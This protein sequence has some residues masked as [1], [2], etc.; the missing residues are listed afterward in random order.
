MQA[1]EKNPTNGVGF[2]ATLLKE[3]PYAIAVFDR[4]M[5]YIA[6]SHR[7]L[8]EYNMGNQELTG[9]SHYDI[10]PEISTEWRNIHQKCLA[11]ES[12]S[13]SDD[14]F[15]RLDGSVDYVSWKLVPWRDCDGGICG[16]IMFTSVSTSQVVTEKQ[17]H[18]YERDLQVLLQT[19]RAVPWRM[20]VSTETFT[21]MGSQLESVVGYPE[22]SWTDLTT[23][24][25]HIHPDDRERV[26][27]IIRD[28]MT[29]SDHDFEYRVITPSN[30]GV[31]IRSVVSPI[32]DD[33]DTIVAIAGLCIDIN[34]QKLTEQKLRLSEKQYRS[35]IALSGDG[36]WLSDINGTLLEVNDAYAKLSGYSNDELVGMHISE[37]DVFDAP[38][39][40]ARQNENIIKNGS[41]LFETKH[42][43]KNGELWDV[44]ISASYIDNQGG[45]FCVFARDITERK[46]TQEELRLI[47]MVFNNTSEG[48]VITNPQGTIIDVNE[49]YCEITGYSRNEMLG[50]KPSKI[51]S[52][53]HD[54]EFY[55]QMWSSL[56][57]DGYWV[58]EIW[59]RRKNGEVFP[60]W[61]NINAV[62][63]E[64]GKLSHYVG[65]FSDISSLKNIESELEYMAYHDHLTGLPNRLLFM[66]RVEN[67]IKHCHR[68]GFQ[69]AIL[70]LDIDRFKLINDSL[71]HSAGDA[72][73]IEVSKRI[74]ANLREND[75]VARMGGDEFTIL[76]SN[77]GGSDA[78]A[79]VAKNIMKQ[80]MLPF[81]LHGEELRLGSSIGI[82]LYPDDGTNFSTLTRHADAAMYEAKDAGRG[83]YRFFSNE[84]DSSVHEH[85]SLE[86][87]L[88][89]ALENGEF[90][91]VFQPQVNVHDNRVVHCEAL[92]RWKH[93]ERG[94][95]PPDKFIPIAETTG[96][97]SEIGDWIIHESCRIISHWR[98]T[99]TTL[100]TVSINLSA[101]QFR[102]ESLVDK[103][104]AILA[105][106]N[107]DAT[108]VE[109]EITETAAMENAESTMERLSR[110]TEKG[111]SI[112]I[113]DFGTG[114]S[115]LSYLKR[116]PVNKLKLDRSFVMDIQTDPNDA[117][118]S[119]AIIQMA[120]SLGLEI[121]AEGVET[122]EQRDFLAA[123]G[124]SIMQGYLYSKPLESSDFLDY[125][126]NIR[127][128]HTSEQN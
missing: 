85:L 17:L 41:C 60:K 120:N 37:L 50:E 43:K 104:L 30:D 29:G 16:I 97:I 46:R 126:I 61:L 67:E 40:V 66:D 8:E 121:V 13:R 102:Q 63:D 47:A 118:I 10:F 58:G 42:R 123:K 73:L 100:P 54:K 3:V 28:A 21:S 44:E 35:V 89:R 98:D 75:T 25:S 76:L 64:E 6:Y 70:F 93:P 4:Q 94:L 127:Y 20:N 2:L 96:L 12:L 113:D 119:S 79:V 5:R 15:P 27:S 95:V 103:I 112:A 115:S 59:D 110:L 109:F 32:R 11:G 92:T 87:D 117:A 84:M 72:L 86:R 111:F 56:L 101:Q 99:L 38:E 7:W 49:A 57:D 51:K 71:G 116:F 62:N 74:K 77:I 23:W 26:A 34:E 83:Q 39:A 45:Q 82:S 52:D 14:P 90:Y 91:L 1:T 53:K 31:W 114:Y 19:T 122:V 22:D 124:C 105:D 68:N 24:L 81:T 128:G 48:I 106:Y 108:A 9:H 88:R 107:V 69:C 18:Q 65:I 55:K 125:L 80:I 78:A 36:F 33:N